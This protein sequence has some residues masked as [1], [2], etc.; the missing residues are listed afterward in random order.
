MEATTEPSRIDA[1]EL[2]R[3]LEDGVRSVMSSEGWRSFLTAQARFHTYSPG[4]VLLI[5]SQDPH[6]TRVAGFHTW[7]ELG[8]FVKKGEHGIAILAPVFPKKEPKPEAG[9]RQTGE[10]S[11][12]EGKVAVESDHVPVRFRVAHVFDIAQTDGEP[13][14]E[15]PARRLTGD[16]AEAHALIARLTRLVEQEGLGLEYA[17]PKTMPRGTNGYY[18]PM[19]GRIV[20]SNALAPDQ[21]AK[22]LAHE[23]AHH[24]LEHERG[25]Q[26]GRP[27]EEA[28]AEG[29]AFVVCSRF[30]LDTSNYSFGYVANWSRDDGGPALVKQASA[31][32]QAVAGGMIGRMEAERAHVAAREHREVAVLER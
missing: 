29:V 28:E 27:T 22:T 20:V 10:A 15:A 8:R 23:L 21:Q 6:A 25:R 16:S 24:M 3:R 30:G 18:Q 5:L 13:L 7:R 1:S 14:P 19:E 9:E 12:D 26:P 31:A 2:L 32:I 4:N 17:D 11:S